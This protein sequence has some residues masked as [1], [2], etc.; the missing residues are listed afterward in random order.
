MLFEF[1]PF[2]FWHMSVVIGVLGIL[3]GLS[4]ILGQRRAARRTKAIRELAVQH[5]LSFLG[6][7]Q[8]P[9]PDYPMFHLGTRQYTVNTIVAVRQ[10][11]EIQAG[12]YNYQVE[13]IDREGRRQITEFNF[14]YC[15]APLPDIRFPELIVRPEGAVDKVKAAAGFE[16]IN[17]E[18][19]QF[20]KKYYVQ[21]PI[22]KFASDVICPSMMEYLLERPGYTLH[23]NHSGLLITFGIEHRWKIDKFVPAV[24]FAAGVL[25]RIPEHVYD[26]YKSSQTIPKPPG[27]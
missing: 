15:F 20:S 26:T 9:K 18:S 17:F 22:R 11:W 23:L 6:D 1:D 27:V 24:E 8:C 19:H 14:S 13:R 2:N 4:E 25:E 12:D 10:R 16:D 21:S 3:L 7:K 5:N